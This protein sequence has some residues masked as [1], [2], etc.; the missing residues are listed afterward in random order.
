LTDDQET[1]EAS[2]VAIEVDSSITDVEA[3][4]ELAVEAVEDPDQD[5]A[6]ALDAEAEA[7]AEADAASEPSVDTT[8]TDA[9]ESPPL[10]PDQ[11]SDS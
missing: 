6:L 7:E 1:L 4:P 3:T 8:E 9:D 5:E 11:K 2:D 10:D